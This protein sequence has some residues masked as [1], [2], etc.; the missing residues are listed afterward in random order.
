MELKDCKQ[1][2]FSLNKGQYGFPILTVKEVIGMMTT[3]QVPHVPDFIKGIINL[4]GKIMPVMDLRIKFGMP[5]EPYNERTCIVIVETI[6]NKER[7]QMGIVVDGISEVIDIDLN[8]IEPSPQYDEKSGCVFI[9]G[10]AKIKGKV[11]MLLNI[12]EIVNCEN[13]AN[14][15]PPEKPEEKP[16]EKP[17]E[18]K[19]EKPPEKPAAKTKAAKKAKAEA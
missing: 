17:I 15:F 2:I 18:K 19:E 8:E 1:L 5:E 6:L 16:E 4:R 13:I 9:D 7:K 3:V 14:I 12:Q 10:V 11:V